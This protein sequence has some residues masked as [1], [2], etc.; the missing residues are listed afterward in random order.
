MLK[1]LSQYVREYKKATILTVVFTITEVALG[2]L[3]PMLMGR[4]ID[5]GIMYHNIPKVLQ[6]GFYMVLLAAG[7]LA[8]GILSGNYAA[9]ASSGYAAN[10]RE[11]VYKKV[12]TFSFSNIDKFSSTGII[13]RLTTDITNIQNTYM[14][15]FRLLMRS[16]AT[17][18]SALIMTVFI[19][20][21]LSSIFF[22]AAIFF[23]GILVITCVPAFKLFDTV[24]KKFDNLNANV[25]ENV[26]GIRVVKSFVKE[27]YE[28]TR[29][30]KNIMELYQAF[31]RAEVKICIMIPAMMLTMYA[32]ILAL[33][34][35][36]ANMI[37]AGDLTTGE[38]TSLFAYVM[39]I[40]IS[41]MMLSFA[42]VMI[43][44]SGASAKRVV[45]V[46]REEVDILSPKNA[47]TR[48]VDGSILFENVN[49][50]YK[51]ESK[52]YVLKDI[53]FK[54]ES[55]QTIGIIGGTG[56]SK[57]TLANLISRLYDV[58]SGSVCVGGEDVREYDIP[59]LRNSVSMVLQ[60][61]ELFSGTIL[62]NLRWGD[63]NASLEECQRVCK[64]ACAD[65]FIQNLP[66]KYET[67]IE[68][69]GSNVSGG[70]KQRLCIA[71][72]LLKKP[73]IIIFDDST[74]AVD[75]VTDGKIRKALK[76]E[77]PDLTKIII[78]QR[79]S[80]VKDADKILVLENGKVHGFDTH[81]NLLL[82]NEIYKAVAKVQM[83][84]SADFD[85]MGEIEDVNKTNF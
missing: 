37:V 11:E 71:R 57:T 82:N 10:L 62:E 48:V 40:L 2:L 65:G 42:L 18:I 21:R 20:P 84:C 58:C 36:G 72:G 75:T 85:R 50:S 83:E 81:E 53:N 67:Y 52:K 4:I 45:E 35:F 66:D 32:C 3:I 8:T 27:E 76:E 9:Y 78:A 12:Q 38:L 74:S 6:Y 43:T 70:Q 77:L 16:P 31:V 69:G 33:S 7:G 29:F 24:F 51:K 63:P 13:T 17:L 49:F 54:I 68:Q 30:E 5:A 60:K 41:L 1:E 61:N 73:K 25:Q 80:S 26:K 23:G 64:I 44:L 15:I 39:S 59:T 55:G 22:L 47:I 19:N 28:I 79:I 34:W 56:S 14:L 46:L